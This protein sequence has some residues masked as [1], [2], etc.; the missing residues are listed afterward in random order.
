MVDRSN[1][2]REKENEIPVLMPLQPSH[3]PLPVRTCTVYSMPLLLYSFLL[4]EIAA[5]FWAS[6][7]ILTGVLFLGQL[8][9]T[10]GLVFALGIGVVDFLRLV[11]LLPKLM[12]FSLPLASMLGVILGFNRLVADN[13]F[14][15]LRA[16][17]PPESNTAHHNPGDTFC[18]D[19][20]PC[21]RLFK[22]GPDAERSDEHEGPFC[23][24][25]PG[26]NRP[27]HH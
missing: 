17:E 3:W 18:V 20:N 2:G 7:V 11:Y 6:L 26:E 19:S 27:G 23:Q 5:P 10:F 1:R 21:G 15:A 16:S 9:Q 25:G 8:L 4:S 13:E 24:A 14:L 12:M 22:R